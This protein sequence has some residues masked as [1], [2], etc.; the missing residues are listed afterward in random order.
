MGNLLHV[1][2]YR[3]S[4]VIH[5][6]RWSIVGWTTREG[7]VSVESLIADHHHIYVNVYSHTPT[8]T[9]TH[10]QTCWHEALTFK[11]WM[12][13]QLWL[14]QDIWDLPPQNRSLWFFGACNQP[15]HTQ[16]PFQS[17]D[18]QE[19]TEHYSYMYILL[20]SVLF[21]PLSDS[22]CSVFHT[23]LCLSLILF[24]FLFISLSFLQCRWTSSQQLLPSV[25]SNLG[26]YT[27]YR[28]HLCDSVCGYFLHYSVCGSSG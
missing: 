9:Q 26:H 27:K 13:H 1:S 14:P 3:A 18:N 2:S 12:W 25:A 19:R 23:R 16:G 4:D 8:S 15:H 10:I 22:V 6:E 20:F 24:T 17:V 28:N 11:L 5:T 21:C 7:S